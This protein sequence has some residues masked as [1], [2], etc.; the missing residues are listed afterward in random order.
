MT[1]IR[2]WSWT[3]LRTWFFVGV[4]ATLVPW[5]VFLLGAKYVL[6]PRMVDPFERVV[7]V[8]VHEM[9]MTMRLQIALQ[10]A[11]MPA[12]DYLIHGDTAERQL[13]NELGQDVN[14]AFEDVK[15]S[16]ELTHV[17]QD[18]IRSAHG[19]WNA[20]R[21]VADTL[22]ALPSPVGNPVAAAQMEHMD[23][24]LDR[25]VAMLDGVHEI[26]SRE[27]VEML[28]AAR[29]ARGRT[30]LWIDA[31]LVLGGILVTASGL[32]V[33]RAVVVP[34]RL[35]ADG[36]QRFRSGD[37]DYEINIRRPDELNRLGRLCNAMAK[38][39]SRVQTELVI[40]SR[41]DSLTAASNRR[42]LDER[43][44]HEI[45]RARRYDR[46]LS[47]LMLDLDRFKQVNDRYGHTTGD[48]VLRE[49]ARLVQSS[50]RP[51][52]ELFRYGGEE[53]LV[54][55]PETGNSEAAV[56]AERIRSSVAT[57]RINIAPEAAIGV[58]VSIGVTTFPDNAATADELVAA[59]DRALYAAKTG[60]RNRVS[61]SFE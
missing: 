48:S 10:K 2:F 15:S 11:A 5:F 22:L 12:N 38:E 34:M 32:I 53:F 6:L 1:T 9:H 24:R 57:S 47:I 60:G 39:L 35:L 18:L 14:A 41:T 40:Q 27:V 28:S 54:I 30:T 25:A 26:Q 21:A 31:L 8:P 44:E 23:A 36:I 45:E 17:E 33:A 7:Q 51:A 50:I 49:F 19:E 58:T 52:D 20:A 3:S 59:S 42:N 13:A 61:R 43:L 46:K 29:A 16:P 55:L 4:F 37:L 56:V